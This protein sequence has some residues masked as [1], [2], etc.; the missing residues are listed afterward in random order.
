MRFTVVLFKTLVLAS[1]VASVACSN[2]SASTTGTVDAS[3]GPLQP[4]GAGCNASLT[5]PCVPA[6]SACS[7]VACLASVC[8]V[9]PVADAP[10]CADVS[11]PMT[12]TLCDSGADCESGVCGYLVSEGCSVPGV[13][14]AP[15]DASAM[16]PPACGCDGLPDPYVASGFAA[17][18]ALSPV[19]CVDGGGAEGGVDAGDAGSD[20][21]REAGDDDA[22]SGE[23]AESASD[24][25][26]E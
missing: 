24:A 8:T 16:L 1:C 26:S 9:T 14:V 6:A 2:D 21:S 15:V 12:N 11:L 5:N 10:A 20:A 19:A 3:F 22:G 17:A 23:D 13:C 25:A 4:I 7:V 18:P